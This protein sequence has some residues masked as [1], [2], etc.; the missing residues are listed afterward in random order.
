M[1]ISKN[2]FICSHFFQSYFLKIFYSNYSAL[3]WSSFLCLLLSLRMF[4]TS[5]W[6]VGGKSVNSTVLHSCSS[7]SSLHLLKDLLTL[8]STHSYF[9]GRENK[10]KTQLLL[11]TQILQIHVYV[12]LSLSPQFSIKLDWEA[13]TYFNLFFILKETIWFGFVFC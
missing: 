8:D 2:S 4:S 9:L 10:E 3:I 5:I 13:C 1:G 7:S 6:R 12:Q 11:R